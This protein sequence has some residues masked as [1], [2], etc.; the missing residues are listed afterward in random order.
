[1]KTDITQ[2]WGKFEVKVKLEEEVNE[3]PKQIQPDSAIKPSPVSPIPAS[4]TEINCP[5]CTYLNPINAAKCEM[6]GG[7]LR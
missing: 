3:Y 2:P 7:N 6:C 1:V 5:A 4:K